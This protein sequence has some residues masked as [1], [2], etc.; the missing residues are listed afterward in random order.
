MMRWD[1][2]DFPISGQYKIRTQVDDEV[3][4]LIDGVKVQTATIRPP[5]R[6]S[7]PIRYQAFTATAGKKSI[8]LRLRNIRIPNTGFQQ[9]PTAVRMDI[10]VPVDVSTGISRP[11]IDNPVGISAILIPP[12]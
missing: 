2:V 1:N 3:D 7:D 5:E 4:V 8:E 9:N 10:I 11:W 12:P 6:R